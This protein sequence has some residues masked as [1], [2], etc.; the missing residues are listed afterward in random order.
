[1][2]PP[3]PTDNGEPFPECLTDAADIAA[4][5]QTFAA[6]D[7][8]EDAI[9]DLYHHTYA[10]LKLMPIAQLKEGGRNSN[11]RSA[12]N[13]ARYKKMDLRTLP[14]LLVDKGNVVDGNH[15]L[16]AGKKRGLTHMWCYVIEDAKTNN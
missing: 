3:K 5:I 8:D 11:L 16:R 12:E 2:I 6:E 9:R 13:E 7:V 14:P 10:V 4:F 15:R 1:M